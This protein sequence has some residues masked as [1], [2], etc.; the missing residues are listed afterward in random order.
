MPRI[1]SNAGGS[2]SGT[3]ALDTFA[4]TGGQTVFAL[5]TAP[6]TPALVLAFVNGV[7]YLEGVDFT[8]VGAV[9][10]WGNVLFALGPP[11]RL[12]AYYEV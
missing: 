2:G 1:Q 3:F 7:L 10:T 11:D 6:A 4:P 9:F 5:S 12:E 8:V